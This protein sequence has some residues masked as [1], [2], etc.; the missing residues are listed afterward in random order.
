[1]T[2]EWWVLHEVGSDFRECL[3]ARK[4]LSLV[5]VR[6]FSSNRILIAKLK[7][8]EVYRKCFHIRANELGEIESLEHCNPSIVKLHF[9]EG[10]VVDF[11]YDCSFE[12]DN[13][14]KCPVYSTE[15]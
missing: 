10:D 14:D 2:L 15:Y 13:G 11:R 7:G 5:Y 3:K 4:G 1:M 12:P 6:A 9:K 8:E